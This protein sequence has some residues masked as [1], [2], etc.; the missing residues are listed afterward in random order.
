MTARRF[1][2][3]LEAPAK[4]FIPFERS[5]HVVMFEEPG[6]FL[7]SFVTEVLPLTGEA[8]VFGVGTDAPR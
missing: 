4:K 8:A 6:R 3:V 5:A 7:L 2:D 1:Y